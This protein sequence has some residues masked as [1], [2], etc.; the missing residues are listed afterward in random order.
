MITISTSQLNE[1]NGQNL[2]EI[3]SKKL[4]ERILP[5]VQIKIG[6]R[7]FFDMVFVHSIS[8]IHMVRCTQ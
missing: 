1:K 5:C 8:C 2:V 3:K 7:H 4:G 6:Y